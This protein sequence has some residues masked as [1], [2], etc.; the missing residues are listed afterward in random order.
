M[1]TAEGGGVQHLRQQQHPQVLGKR[2]QQ[3]PAQGGEDKT[4]H[5]HPSGECRVAHPIP[6]A[7]PN[8]QLRDS[9]NDFRKNQKNP[10]AEGVRKAI[11]LSQ[12][13]TNKLESEEM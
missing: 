2:T 9:P 11:H 12:A 5:Q 7:N 10:R 1:K 3:Q 4:E 6:K 8:P 13:A